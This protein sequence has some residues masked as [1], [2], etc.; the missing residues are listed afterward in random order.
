M[1]DRLRLAF[2]L[3]ATLAGR[4]RS[5]P[6]APS[7]IAWRAQLPLIRSI[8][9]RPVYSGMVTV[10]VCGTSAKARSS[11]RIFRNHLCQFGLVRA[12]P[13]PGDYYPRLRSDNRRPQR[14]YLQFGSHK[15][16]LPG[17][18]RHDAGGLLGS[19]RP[20]FRRSIGSRRARWSA[21]SVRRRT[22]EADWRCCR[23]S[24]CAS[25]RSMSGH[26]KCNRRRLV[27]YP[28]LWAHNAR[29]LYHIRA[30][31]RPSISPRQ[32]AY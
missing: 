32:V 28:N 13:K 22:L 25:I 7:A 18:F 31:P 12:A 5:D 17:R 16:R 6:D 11:Q 8:E 1:I 15:R 30:L 4:S 21:L 24:C 2:G 3:M 19:G 10:P 27:D 14:P 26:F 20:L 29:Y 23:P 9:G